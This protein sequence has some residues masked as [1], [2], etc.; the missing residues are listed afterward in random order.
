[1]AD[2]P[3]PPPPESRR[4][5]SSITTSA[6]QQASSS[7][8]PTTT[9][10]VPR[11][12]QTSASKMAPTAPPAQSQFHRFRLSEFQRVGTPSASPAGQCSRFR[13]SDF[14]PY[15]SASSDGQQTQPQLNGASPAVSGPAN[16]ASPRTNQPIRQ[17]TIP[18]AGSYSV[19]HMDIEASP[20]QQTSDMVAS[21]GGRG[22][23]HKV[24]APKGSPAQF[25]NVSD[26]I[27]YSSA[28]S[29]T[30]SDLTN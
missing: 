9:S 11:R 10:A 30:E 8:R 19:L 20:P 28:H 17:Q 22:V 12:L 25:P 26:G 3:P 14:V 29:V 1:M 18:G 16:T 7:T 23:L 27:V 6:S 4:D 24:P 15:G 5:V 21:T 2:I 13:V